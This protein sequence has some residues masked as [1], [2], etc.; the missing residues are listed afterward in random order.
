VSYSTC[1]FLVEPTSSGFRVLGFVGAFGDFFQLQ[2]EDARTRIARSWKDALRRT[3]SSAGARLVFARTSNRVASH[4]CS[5]R[6][7]TASSEFHFETAIDEEE[8]KRKKRVQ[9]RAAEQERLLAVKR[10]QSELLA[11][12]QE[13]LLTG[14]IVAASI[15]R[16]PHLRRTSSQLESTPAKVLR[17]RSGSVQHLKTVSGEDGD[18]LG[19]KMM[20]GSF[21]RPRLTVHRDNVRPVEPS[22]FSKFSQKW[23]GRVS[24]NSKHNQPS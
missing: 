7:S 9:R 11:L 23:L 19:K 18:L 14:S 1:R 8:C 10:N 4:G 12:F 15:D 22:A 13:G 24:G 17:K 2:T 3:M 21:S 16:D 5:P 6:P 20:S